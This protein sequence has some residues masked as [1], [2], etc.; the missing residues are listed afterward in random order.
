MSI[1]HMCVSITGALRNMENKRT[2]T[3][4]WFDHEG[5]TPMSVGEAREFLYGELQKGRKVLPTGECDNFD[6]QTGCL[7]HKESE[8]GLQN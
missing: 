4:S 2:K 8:D 5:G 7:G 6:Y 1:R 3:K